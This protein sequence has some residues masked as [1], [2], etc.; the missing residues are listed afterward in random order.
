M[1]KITIEEARQLLAKA[2]D[3][4]GR[5][6]VYNPGG[7]GSC[8][9]MPHN[10]DGHEC[11]YAEDHPCVITGCLVGTAMSLSGRIENMED[12]RAGSVDV[13]AAH[14]SHSALLYLLIAQE[15]QDLGRTWG[16]AFD[17]AEAAVDAC[18]SQADLFAKYDASVEAEDVAIAA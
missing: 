8:Y 12:Y 6:F 18:I 5:D 17:A 10:R 11:K 1:E 15:R 2:V 4:Q 9:N 16:E 3:T 7:K 13:F 14:L